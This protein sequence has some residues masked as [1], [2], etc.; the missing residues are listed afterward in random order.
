M[1]APDWMLEFQDYQ[2][3]CAHASGE[4]IR[5]YLTTGHHGVTYTHSQLPAGANLPRYSCRL[6]AEDT[7]LLLTLTDWRGRLDGVGVEVREW[8]RAHVTLRGCSLDRNRYQGDPY[9]RA[10]LLRDNR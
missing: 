3:L 2:T 5:F 7:E 9:W 10:E 8:I 1:T 4:F 6:T